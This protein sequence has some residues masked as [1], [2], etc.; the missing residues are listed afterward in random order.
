[1]N[2]RPMVES[3]LDEVAAI[4]RTAHSHPWTR[5]QFAGSLAAGHRGLL[6]IDD[7]K[8]VGYGVTMPLPDEAELLDITVLPSRQRQGLGRKLLGELCRCEK[9]T[10][11]TRLYLEVRE[12][13]AAARALYAASG[14]VEIGRRRDY[15]PSEGGR[16]AAILMAKD[17]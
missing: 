12:S 17:L 2:Y 15:Y 4:E 10:G 5:N 14:F 11:A 13:N 7:E 3:D 1:M 9:T 6:M 16:E 8:I